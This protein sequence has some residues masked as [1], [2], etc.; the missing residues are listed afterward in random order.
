MK[1]DV[2]GCALGLTSVVNHLPI[3]KPWTIASTCPAIPNMFRNMTCD[4]THEHTPCA[5]KDIKLSEDYTPIMAKLIHRAH[6]CHALSEVS[7]AAHPAMPAIL[8]LSPKPRNLVLSTF[9]GAGR[10]E[11][12]AMAEG[13]DSS[14]K[15]TRIQWLRELMIRIMTLLNP[16]EASLLR[17]H[18]MTPSDTASLARRLHP[19]SQF[20]HPCACLPAD[21]HHASCRG[22]TA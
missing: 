3:K 14:I 20:R 15:L 1:V 6:K 9:H 22:S 11:A 10:T 13:P 2:H 19:E 4:G 8:Q 16:W 7:H 18:E 17:A 12:T 21:R 5:G